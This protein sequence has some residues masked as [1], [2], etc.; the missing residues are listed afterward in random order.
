[1]LKVIKNNK[2]PLALYVQRKNSIKRAHTRLKLKSFDKIKLFIFCSFFM[3]YDLLIHC[4]THDKF[5]FY[6]HFFVIVVANMC[7][8]IF[9]IIYDSFWS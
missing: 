7:V 8:Y 6:G 2:N 5:L 9:F 3:V 4:L 1:M